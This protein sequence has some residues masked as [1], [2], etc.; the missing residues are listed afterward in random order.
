MWKNVDSVTIYDGQPVCLFAGAGR[1][2][3]IK[4]ADAD[5]PT[6]SGMIGFYTGNTPLTVGSIGRVVTFGVIRDAPMNSYID[7][8]ASE[9][10]QLY[11]SATAGHV[12]TNVP[13][14]PA[15]TI[16]VGFLNYAHVPS[17]K[18]DIQ[19]AIENAKPWSVLDGRYVQTTDSRVVNAITNV[20]NLALVATPISNLSTG[21]TVTVTPTY[22]KKIY[23]VDASVPIT[24]FTNNLSSVALNGTTNIEWT[25]RINYTSTNAL[26]TA[27]ESRIEWINGTPDLTVT[28][29]YE[30]AFSTSDGVKIQGRQVYPTVYEWSAIG[31]G[32]IN[33][34]F[35]N[36]HLTYAIS[37]SSSASN[38][39]FMADC[40]T[41]KVPTIFE[42]SYLTTADAS[43]ILITSG[44]SYSLV[45]PT[46]NKVHTNSISISSSAPSFVRTYNPAY[47]ANNE[48]FYYVY[49]FSP[50]FQSG[51]IVLRRP[52]SRPAN[53]LEVKAYS[54]GWRP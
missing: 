23:D 50:A 21:A 31:Y 41:P 20:S 35:K 16:K 43:G 27:W 29:R 46:A 3:S 18:Y 14:A 6:R 47:T 48:A 25:T 37:L 45:Q 1:V 12:T 30:F 52:M 10:A 22:Q 4:L 44:I 28:G 19:V 26:S 24:L 34:T 17:N 11:L 53:E 51:N 49:V 36:V 32:T 8:T 15:E 13:V 54:Q 40:P 42:T 33:T 7:G 38:V 9:G 39:Y 2:G 5:D